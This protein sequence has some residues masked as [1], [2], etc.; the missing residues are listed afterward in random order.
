MC[1]TYGVANGKPAI[2]LM[3]SSQ[4]NGANIMESVDKVRALLPHL[5][6][7]I[8]AAIDLKVVSDRTPT[9][10]ASLREVERAGH[11]DGSGHLGGVFVPAQRAGHAHSQRGGAGCRWRA[12]LP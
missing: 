2:L 1:A 3:C 7:S 10:R 5:Q 9:I 12:R 8:P 11:L 4:P 6:A